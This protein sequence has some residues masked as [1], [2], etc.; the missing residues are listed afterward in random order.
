M[1]N[2]NNKNNI[3]DINN[4]NNDNNKRSYRSRN[5]CFTINIKNNDNNDNDNNNKEYINKLRNEIINNLKEYED[6][7]RYY[8]MG[9]ELGKKNKKWH[10]QGFIQLNNPKS[11][12]TI[13]N[14]F[15]CKHMNLSKMYSNVISASNYCKKDNNYI[16]YGKYINQ[17][18]RTDIELIYKDL[19]NGKSIKY[20]AYNHFNTWTKYYKAFDR[21]KNIL[22][23]DKASNWRN[24]KTTLIKGP[25]GIG[26]TRY[27]YL[28][29]NNNDIYKIN[30]KQLNWWDGYTGQKILLIDEYSNDINITELLNILDGYKLRLP[31]KGGFTYANWNKVYITTNLDIL[32]DNAKKEHKKALNRRINRVINTFNNKDKKKFIKNINKKINNKNNNK[33]NDNN[34]DN[35]NNKDIGSNSN[36]EIIL[37]PKKDKNNNI[38]TKNNKIIYNKNSNATKCSNSIIINNNKNKNNNNI[39]KN[40]N[41]ITKINNKNNNN[42]NNDN[43]NELIEYINEL[44]NDNNKEYISGSEN[45]SELGVYDSSDNFE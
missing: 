10:I 19:K 22:D 31:I 24:I 40:K 15:D 33:D 43:N 26:K 34:K 12:K 20:I 38:H 6:L 42:K 2:N 36:T 7:I 5:W 13:K 29:H 23:E 45:E 41:N 25:T 32:H 14:I 1:N 18:Q 17:G 8:I 35:N 16:E 11:M 37:E 9:I 3:K 21:F 30:G 44:I 39:N 4:N 27:T 28:K